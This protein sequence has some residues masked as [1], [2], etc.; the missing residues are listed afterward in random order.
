[1]AIGLVFLFVFV[2]KFKCS[3]N[4]FTDVNIYFKPE[5]R[6]KIWLLSS[7]DLKISQPTVIDPRQRDILFRGRLH[8]TKLDRV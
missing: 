2:K 8:H 6:D 5:H 1:M 4:R 7:D 3:S